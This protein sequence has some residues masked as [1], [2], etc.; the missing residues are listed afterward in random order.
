MCGSRTD[1]QVRHKL[2]P[3][4]ID[5]PRSREH[6]VVFAEPLQAILRR[7]DAADVRDRQLQLALERRGASFD[8]DELAGVELVAVALDLFHE[9]CGNL[10]GG[11][12]QRMSDRIRRCGRAGAPVRSRES[13]PS[14]PRQP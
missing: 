4:L 9:A 14:P 1:C 13:S 5:G 10:A 7:I 3:H 6:A 11:V 8:A 12:L 2:R